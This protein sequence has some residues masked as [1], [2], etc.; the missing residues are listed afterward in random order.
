[1]LVI[2]LLQKIHLKYLNSIFNFFKHFYKVVEYRQ[3]QCRALQEP[4]WE[5]DAVKFKSLVNGLEQLVDDLIISQDKSSEYGTILLIKSI[6]K[7]SQ[8][9]FESSQDHIKLQNMLS[10]LK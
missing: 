5:T 6:I 3:K 2:I 8:E 7:K 9:Y 4:G 10:K 1:M